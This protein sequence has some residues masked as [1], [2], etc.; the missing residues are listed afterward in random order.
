VIG[1]AG[2]ALITGGAALLWVSV[3][4]GLQPARLTLK[5]PLS[6]IVPLVVVSAVA[7]G[8]TLLLRAFL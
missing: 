1:A 2:L 8:V 7:L 6:W 4:R 5:G 3:P